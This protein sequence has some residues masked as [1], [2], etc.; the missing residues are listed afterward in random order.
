MEVWVGIG[1]PPKE[2][3]RPVVAE[4]LVAKPSK[5]SSK[6]EK[7]VFIVGVEANFFKLNFVIF[8]K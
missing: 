4:V 5:N 8:H 3:S 2:S 1:Q 7:K 6:N